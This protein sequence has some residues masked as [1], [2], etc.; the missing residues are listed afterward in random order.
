[1]DEKSKPIQSYKK[2]LTVG[3]AGAWE[4]IKGLRNKFFALRGEN[5]V[6]EFYTFTSKNKMKAYM[7][8]K[9]W[10]SLSVTPGVENFSFQTYEILVGSELTM[11]LGQWPRAE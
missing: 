5:Q 2:L 7:E 11:D 1:L 9:L 8:G 4:G 10:K 6:T 3:Y